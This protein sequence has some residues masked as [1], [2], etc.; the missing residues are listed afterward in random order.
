MQEISCDF[1]AMAVLLSGHFEK[2]PQNSR[3]KLRVSAIFVKLEVK[4]FFHKNVIFNAFLPDITK[5]EHFCVKLKL[6]ML[7]MVIF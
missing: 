6:F 2:K 1:V 7:K 4:I 3:A 5:A